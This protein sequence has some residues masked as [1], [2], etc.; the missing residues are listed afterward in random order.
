MNVERINAELASLRVG[1]QEALLFAD[2]P[3]PVV[4]YR[5][6]PT[7]GARCGLPLVADVIVPVPNGHPAATID[8][9]GLEAGSPL[10]PRVKG[11]TNSQGVVVVDG[12]QFQLAS[13]HPHNGGGGPPYDPLKH[14]FHT[15][16]D[17]ILAWLDQFQ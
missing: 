2:A 9:A 14:G 3:R 6:V 11:G 4:L 15:Y 1:G 16:F 8:L 12:R 7:A 13:Y 17:H 5:A 10:L